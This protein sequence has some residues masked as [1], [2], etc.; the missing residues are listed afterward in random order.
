VANKGGVT[1]EGEAGWPLTMA[2]E[3]GGGPVSRGWGAEDG[4]A[5]PACPRDK[6]EGRA[7]TSV[8]EEKG[9]CNIHFL[10]E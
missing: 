2:R 4:G 1:G 9:R 7:C 3:T 10:Q 6:D 8:R 5:R